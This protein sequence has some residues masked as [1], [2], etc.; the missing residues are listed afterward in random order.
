MYTL[1]SSPVTNT[2][3]NHQDIISTK[4][5]TGD[6]QERKT[7]TVIVEFVQSLQSGKQPYPGKPW[8]PI[9][10]EIFKRHYENISLLLLALQARCVRR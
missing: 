10:R 3:Q 4:T 6:R 5:T 9:L 8:R 1:N 7:L 2:S